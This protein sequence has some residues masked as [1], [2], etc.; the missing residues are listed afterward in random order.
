MMLRLAVAW[1][2]CT[3]ALATAAPVPD[4]SALE[5]RAAQEVDSGNLPSLAVAVVRDGEI[6]YA[7]AF[8]HA[9]LAQRRPATVHTAYALASATKP[10]TATAVMQLAERGKIDLAAPARRYL[11]PLRLRA[12]DPAWPAPS[13]AQLLDHTAGL[14]TYAHIYFGDAVARAPAFA[15]SVERFGV[16]VQPPGRVAEYSN[17]GYGL[18]GDIVERRGGA[19]FGDYLA[20]EVFAPLGMTDAFVDTPQPGADVATPYD[21][22]NAA[23]PA[24]RNDTP[25]A[26]NVQ[27][28]A[29]DLV[30]FARFHLDPASAEKPVLSTAG[31]RRMQQRA[32][33]KA[34]H[35]YY[36]GAYYGLG[37]YVRP[38]DGGER[39]VW[40]EGGM[41]G[42]SSIIKL[43][44]E[45][46]IGVVVLA[47]KSEVNAV[48]QAVADDAL[49]AL[50]PGYAP[51]PLDA[52][53]NY[54]RYAAQPDFLGEWRGSVTV[55]GRKL[56]CELRFGD[57][58]IA[59]ALAASDDTTRRARG[60]F[61]GIVYGDSFVG[62][63]PMALPIA[64]Q[65][66]A[67]SPLLL[68]KLVRSG[69]V[70]QGAFVAYASPQRLEYLL[71]FA[72]RMTRTRRWP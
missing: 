4:F 47:N 12:A 15:R 3:A 21:A 11:G 2:A 58:K 54:A 60:E 55:G 23:L 1:I 56:A 67:G 63:V 20:R 44:P 14:A 65:S 69:D 10:I 48:T 57:G 24:L 50:L 16:L 37:W 40:H 46:R 33:A 9:D 41:P 31:V 7:R 28:S 36:A 6:V 39:A 71:P 59:L 30:R 29:H 5:R 25:G 61:A 8:G 26:G 35:H 53:A 42:A 34:L 72:V 22:Q 32:D 17:L 64:E 62:A 49:R 27:A 66:G 70:L 38:D 45:R 51:G 43:L 52:T 18:L 13:V 68:V 19:G